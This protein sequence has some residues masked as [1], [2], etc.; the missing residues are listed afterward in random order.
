MPDL[1]AY[2]TETHI[3]LIA[4]WC[5]GCGIPYG[6]PAGFIEQRR[7]DN[8][9]WTC[10]NGCKRHFAAGESDAE[11]LRR[12]EAREVALK[13]QLSAAIRDAEQVRVALL[14]DR[15]RFVN[16]VCPCCNRSFDNVRR[17]MTTKHPDY[18]VTRV[19]QPS[20]VTFPCSCGSS[21]TTLRGLRAHQGHMRRD[22]WDKPGAS[23]WSSHLTKVSTS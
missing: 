3:Q 15:Q 13:D 9:T 16:G 17:H 7:Q 6:L 1:F 11:K 20:T 23:R 18:D 19:A 4:H 22:G 14:R 8:E 2:N 10:P 5:N 12:A 21:F